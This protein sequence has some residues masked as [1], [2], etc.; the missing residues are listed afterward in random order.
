M[1]TKITSVILHS[2]MCE[3]VCLEMVFLKCEY[4]LAHVALKCKPGK[5]ICHKLCIHNLSLQLVMSILV[6]ILSHRKNCRGRP[7][8]GQEN[9]PSPPPPL[10][11]PSLP[12]PPAPSSASE[13]DVELTLHHHDDEDD[14]GK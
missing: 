12:P 1:A 9:Q 13:D 14:I 2:N 11:P 10:S 3:Y 4:E 6:I 7:D 5:M 8:A